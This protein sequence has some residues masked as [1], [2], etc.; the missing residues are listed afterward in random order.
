MKNLFCCILL[1]FGAGPV[2]A[3]FHIGLSTGANLS[4]WTWEIKSLNTDIDYEPAMGWR[5][6]V[7]AEYQITPVFGARIEAGTQLKANKITRNLVF[8]SGYPEGD[9]DRTS[10]VFREKY[11]FWEVS[12]LAQIAPIKQF[13]QAFLLLGCTAGKLQKGW[14]TAKGLEAGMKFSKKESIDLSDPNWNR[15]AFAADFG[16]G[17]NFPLGANSLIKVE[18]RFQY[19]LSNL[20]NSDNVNASVN[21]L[22]LNV[23]YMH[24]L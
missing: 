4:F 17:G 15:N 11:Q 24:R 21:P 6:A 9:L 22:I 2:F 12:A 3:Q 16:V 14:K 19:S 7:L 18:A 23:G 8:E 5:G 20:S 10:G 1:A 13:R